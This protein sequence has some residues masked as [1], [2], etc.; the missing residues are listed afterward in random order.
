M[1]QVGI[2]EISSR[3]IMT[4]LSDTAKQLRP[5]DLEGEKGGFFCVVTIVG[6]FLVMAAASLVSGYLPTHD[7]IEFHGLSHYFYRAFERGVVPYWNPY[8]QTGTP[9][10]N[11]Y[12]SFQLMLPSQFVFIA[13]QKI[14]GCTTLTTYVLHHFFMYFIFILGTFFTVRA[15]LRSIGNDGNGN[16]I[17]L[18][19]SLILLMACFPIFMR[20]AAILFLIPFITFFLL[21]FFYAKNLHRKGLYLFLTSFLISASL[22]VYI[23]IWLFFYLMMFLILSFV[24]KIADI[25]TT[26]RFFIGK[27]GGLWTGISLIVSFCIAAPVIALYCELHNGFVYIPTVRFLQKNGNNLIKFFASDLRES[28]FSEGFYVNV[29]ISLTSGNLLG[30][31][32]EPFQYLI[33][34]IA[35][36]EVVLYL[37]PFVLMGIWIA[38]KKARSR[39][40]YVFLITGLLTLLVSCNFSSRVDAEASIFQH[41]LLTMFPFMRMSDVF[42]NGGSLFLFC[43][44]ILGA[45]GFQQIP[46]T[47]KRRVFLIIP[48]LFPL[49]KYGLVVL[50]IRVSRYFASPRFSIY[51]LKYVLLLAILCVVVAAIILGVVFLARYLNRISF[52]RLY[53]L[54]MIVLFMDLL[55]FGIFHVNSINKVANRRYFDYVKQEHLLTREPERAFINYRIPFAFCGYEKYFETIGVLN[56]RLF[57]TFYG[58]EMYKVQKTAFPYAVYTMRSNRLHRPYFA[59]W[60]HLYMTTSFYDY[61]VHVAI[62]KQLITS[63]VVSPI[64]N[65]FPAANV[66][67]VSNKYEAVER[68]NASEPDFLRSHIFIERGIGS[69]ASEPELLKLFQKSN[70][71]K[72][73]EEEVDNVDKKKNLRYPPNPDVDLSVIDYDINHLRINVTTPYDGYFYFGDGYNRH[74]KAFVDGNKTVIEKANINFKSVYTP[75]GD[76]RIE[77]VYDPVFFRYSLYLYLVGNI[78]FVIFLGIALTA[79]K[80]GKGEQSDG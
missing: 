42:Q 65:F 21:Q 78:L 77:F 11:N 79:L 7:A 22:N 6:I 4:T 13:F 61:L 18:M 47:D 26:L 36:S 46:S 2:C 25:K 28:L 56:G 17:S 55:V 74:W 66:I 31:L 49:L 54:S 53:R 71:V 34:G 60:D 19:F 32:I 67:T 70:Y 16:H 75:K 12:Q 44:V 45:I 10:F 27:V 1:S 33:N 48:F 5:P 35:S 41:A 40:T 73:T 57:N 29:K 51:H 76:H 62:D 38:L 23:P 8:S 43:L 39:Y 63:S 64:L 20:M 37:G 69:T 72:Y 50:W 80:I 14:T 68:I 30:M 52:T 59:D 24:F 9:F 3:H 58:I 15:I